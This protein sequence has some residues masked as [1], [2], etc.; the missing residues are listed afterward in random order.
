MFLGTSTDSMRG[1]HMVV[2]FTTAYAT[3]P[4]TTEVVSSYPT[5]G[6]VYSIQQYV[7]KFV[8]DLGMS[9]VFSGYSGFL[10]DITEILLKVALNTLTLLL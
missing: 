2:G 7:I 3:V 10:H 8:T 9:V 1:S 6:K 5:H 4:I